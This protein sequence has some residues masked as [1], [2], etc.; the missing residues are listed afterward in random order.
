[1]FTV[2]TRW[3]TD[4]ERR[5]VNAY[6]ARHHARLRSSTSRVDQALAQSDWFERRAHILAG[7]LVRLL[8]QRQPDQELE[9]LRRVAVTR[10][11]ITV[12]SMVA[13]CAV[14]AAVFVY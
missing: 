14:F 8:F 7:R 2:V 13:S 9:R 12:V 3:M 5:Y 1:M 4:A 6:R 11:Q 10:W